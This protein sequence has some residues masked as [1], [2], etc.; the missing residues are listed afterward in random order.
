[1][2]LR[3]AILGFLSLEPTSGYT[4]KQR[5]DGSVGSFWSATQSQ[6]YRELYGLEAEGLVR[7]ATLPGEGKPD[8]KVYSLTPTGRAALTRWLDEPLE[9]LVLRHP[10][11]LKFVFAAGVPPEALDA[12]LARFAQDMRQTRSEYVARLDDQ[13][14]FSLARSPREREVWKLGI[15]HGIAWCDAELRWTGRARRALARGKKGGKRWNRTA[16]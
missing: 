7:A 11:L 8:R 5:F 6:I 12:T 14:I 1:M 4:L 3:S 16:R 13:R 9:P 2:S 10:M 15:E